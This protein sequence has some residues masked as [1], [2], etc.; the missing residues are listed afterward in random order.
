MLEDRNDDE[1]MARAAGGDRAAFDQ[2]VRRHQHHLQR[3]ASRML[4]GDTDRGADIAVGAFLRLWDYRFEYRACGL[5]SAWLSRTA[6][7][8]CIDSLR[9]Q[10][11]QELSDAEFETAASE[12]IEERELA[13][14]VREAVG[15]LPEALRA[16]LILSV[17]EEMSY[18]QI[19]QVLDIPIGTVGSRRSQAIAVLRRRLS[20][21]KEDQ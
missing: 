13:Q 15:S 7:R 10:R 8:L 11:C 5:L 3:F 18:E 20:A 14:A 17:Y 16:V 2:I 6:Y 1:L 12:V 21:W 4:G 19:S 9:T